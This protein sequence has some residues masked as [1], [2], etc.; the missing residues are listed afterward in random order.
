VAIGLDPKNPAAYL[1]RGLAQIIID[2]KAD[3][4]SDINKAMEL[5][6]KDV[7]AAASQYCK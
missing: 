3:A 4:C 2:D 6:S 1:Q 5:G 7:P